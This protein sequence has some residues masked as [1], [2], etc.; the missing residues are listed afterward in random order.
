MVNLYFD[1]DGVLAKWNPNVSTEDTFKKGY[2][3]NPEPDTLMIELAKEMRN[4]PGVRVYILTAV[5]DNGYAEEEK[6]QWLIN[7][8][9]SNFSFVYVPYGLD[10]ASAVNQSVK[11]FLID[12]YSV[13]LH[14]W[15]KHK[16]FF[17]IKYYNGFNGTNG[18]WLGDVLYYDMLLEN[19]KSA[20]LWYIEKS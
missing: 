18:T 14:N 4:Q 15:E 8:G 10:K 12:D 1:M 7:N 5:Y 6:K 16:N 20:L 11:S 17:G 9:L 13:N 3:L 2:F 19:A